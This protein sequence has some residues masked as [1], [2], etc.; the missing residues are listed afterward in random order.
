MNSATE[1]PSSSSV[2]PTRSSR[3]RARVVGLTLA[4]MVRMAAPRLLSGSRVI[5][6]PSPKPQPPSA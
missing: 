6:G 4:Q 2:S 3:K 5:T 1:E